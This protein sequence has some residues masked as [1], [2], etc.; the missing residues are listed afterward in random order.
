MKKEKTDFKNKKNY[1]EAF[2]LQNTS[3]YAN[4]FEKYLPE[5]QTN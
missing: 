2:K 4:E 5:S 1:S 3:S